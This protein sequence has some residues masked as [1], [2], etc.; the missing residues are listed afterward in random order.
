LPNSA[1]SAGPILDD[2]EVRSDLGPVH[3]YRRPDMSYRDHLVM[4]LTSGAEVEHALMVQYLY[5]AYSINGDQ[6]SKKHR[7]MVEGWR[8]SIL[9][10]A[11]E[12]M[13]HLLTVQNVLVLLG[14]PLNL[15]RELM[16]WDHQFYPFPFSLEPLSEQSLQC[17]I[18]AEMPRL[19][20]IGS[21][22]PGKKREKSVASM[23]LDEQKK[24]IR[25]ITGKLARRFPK[26]KVKENVH[27]V[28][29]LYDEIIALISDPEKIPDSAFND[30]SFDMQA[31]WDDWARGYK[32]SPKLVDPGGSL[33]P[34]HDPASRAP[35]PTLAHRDA[36]VQ[37][38]RAATRAQAVKAL[39]ALAAQGEAPH[40]RE[41][42]TGEPS[43]FDRF[44]QIYKEFNALRKDRSC[45]PVHPVP[46]NP[47]T[48]KDFHK[49][50]PKHTTY[51]GIAWHDEVAAH[52]FAQLFNQ[53]YRLLLTYLAHTFRLAR[54]EPSH[55]PGLRGMVMHRVFGEMYNL[56]AI[57]D[58]LVRL[59]RHGGGCA[60]PPFEMPYSLDLPQAERDIWRQ[61]NDLLA[62]SYKTCGEVLRV[63]KA[64]DYED[65]DRQITATGGDVY[66]RTLMNIDRET[67]RWIGNILAGGGLSERADR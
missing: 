33:D 43:H 10:V 48:R 42:D 45:K 63:A 40:L 34:D 51:I 17:F 25:E 49:L 13:G 38:D 36:H 1:K 44:V 57:A 6:K 35:A 3:D 22:A 23:S 14:A 60:G 5:A 30:A 46:R 55:Q 41:D 16:P 65:M 7:A 31:S 52:Y 28:G 27:R 8:A 59:P 15:G 54:T 2:V 12:E 32:P 37:V 18:Y 62:S 66:V 24:I 64:K 4:M 50:H 56:K 21:A 39:R 9:S 19:E 61:Y 11:R 47:T 29:E 53:R 26:K 67:Q 20:S 58:L